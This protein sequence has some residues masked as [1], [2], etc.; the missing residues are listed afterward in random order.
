MRTTLFAFLSFLLFT[1]IAVDAQTQLFGDYNFN[2]GEYYMLGTSWGGDRNG[3]H[4]SIGEF[5]VTD[6]SLLNQIKKE[7]TFATPSPRYG[8]GYHYVIY[9]CKEG[10]PLENYSI[11]LN[12]NQIIGDKGC[13]YFDTQKLRM[14]AGRLT[15]KPMMKRT[16]FQSITEAR[17]FRDSALANPKLLMTQTPNWV[18]FEGNFEFTYTCPDKKEGCLSSAE[19]VLKQL[20]NEIRVAYPGEQFELEDYGGS[21]TEVFVRVKCNKSLEEKF[22]LYHRH[23]QY[24][25]WEAYNPWLVT[26]WIK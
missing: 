20:T 6:T 18:R 12:C 4:D 19:D 23:P 8:C 25:A 9:I 11:N 10:L 16:T 14:F 3:L 5:Y 21:N 17:A 13:F 26:Y 2:S 1:P 7:W 15:T 24:D 22:T